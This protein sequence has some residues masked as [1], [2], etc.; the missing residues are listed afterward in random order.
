MKVY[1]L[2][3]LFHPKKENIT[4]INEIANQV[5]RLYL[6]DNSEEDNSSLFNEIKNIR[7]INLSDNMGLP[8]AFNY[9]LK[10]SS[11]N[12]E[13]ED[14]ILFFDQDS[15]IR[16]S[17]VKDEISIFDMLA[18][19]TNIG[20]L[21]IS[22][23]NT[24]S[25]TQ[26]IPRIKKEISE[27]CYIVNDVITSSMLTRYGIIKKVNFWNEDL[28]LDCADWD[29]CWRLKEVGYHI[30]ITNKVIFEHSVGTGDINLGLVKLRSCPPIR[31]YY[32][33]RDNLNLIKKKYTPF[34]LRINM[35]IDCTFFNVLRVIFLPETKIRVKLMNKAW[36]DSIRNVTGKYYE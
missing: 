32:R 12:W 1:A 25:G 9:V 13:D 30:C 26:E 2:V 23:F 34:R 17:H 3:T 7:Y 16:S 19:K 5:D 4:G 33:T 24:S 10:D 6:L 29:L 8:K 21:G 11:L 36:K 31:S 22:Y 15:V 18:Q 28:F 20:C 27:G 14:Y 35:I